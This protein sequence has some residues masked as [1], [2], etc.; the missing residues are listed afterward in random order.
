MGRTAVT[1][2]VPAVLAG[3]ASPDPAPGGPQRPYEPDVG[4]PRNLDTLAVTAAKGAGRG[5][6]M[7]FD[8]RS[9]TAS[10]QVPAAARRFVFLF[11]RSVRF[12]GPGRHPAA[13][14]HAPQDRLGTS[15]RDP[16]VLSPAFRR[17]APP[18]NCRIA[19]RRGTATR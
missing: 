5:V 9:R 19:R 1:A 15:R 13:A 12:M 3:T 18:P 17:R 16:A 6:A 4:G 7:A 2:L 10:G 11:D 14:P 8:R